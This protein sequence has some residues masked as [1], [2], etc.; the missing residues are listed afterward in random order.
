MKLFRNIVKIKNF[1]N[2]PF[3]C[4]K[5]CDKSGKKYIRISSILSCG[6][7]NLKPISVVC[8][9]KKIHK[10]LKFSLKMALSFFGTERKS[11]GGFQ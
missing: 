2:R 7:V 3:K 11:F 6:Q 8:D 10:K 4:F 1:L 5:K 9:N